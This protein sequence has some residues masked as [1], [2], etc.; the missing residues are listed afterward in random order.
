MCLR[1]GVQHL[2]AV[3]AKVVD[4]G[5][6]LRSIMPADDEGEESVHHLVV[7]DGDDLVVVA[8]GLERGSAVDSVCVV[9]W[10]EAADRY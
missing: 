10:C 3:T 9:E 6:A 2:P 4:V 7:G 8:L 1:V 5:R